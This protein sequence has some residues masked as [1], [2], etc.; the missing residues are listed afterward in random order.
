VFNDLG[1]NDR[2]ETTVGKRY[3]LGTG[4]A[5]NF[6][7]VERSRP[8]HTYMF[9]RCEEFPIRLETTSNI[10]ELTPDKRAC[11][12]NPVQQPPSRESGRWGDKPIIHLEALPLFVEMNKQGVGPLLDHADPTIRFVI[13]A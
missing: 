5:I 10:K 12:L 8:I 13:S 11:L 4:D 2:I 9:F 1:A 6:D 7:L 3:G